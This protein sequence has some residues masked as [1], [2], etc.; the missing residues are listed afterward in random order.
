ML[1]LDDIKFDILDQTEPLR[2]DILI[3][4]GICATKAGVLRNSRVLSSLTHNAK[5]EQRARVVGHFGDRSQCDVGSRGA[6]LF[7]APDIRPPLEA[8]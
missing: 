8:S 4:L 7:I 6:T 2:P 3:S 5:V 1:E